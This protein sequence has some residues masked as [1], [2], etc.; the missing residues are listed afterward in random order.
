M[1]VVP[2]HCSGLPRQR[3]ALPSS[4]PRPRLRGRILHHPTDL[5]VRAVQV[6]RLLLSAGTVAVASASAGAKGRM[7]ERRGVYTCTVPSEKGLMCGT[8]VYFNYLNKWW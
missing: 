7:N 4:V 8:V 6:S 5:H 1:P 3:N 2:Q